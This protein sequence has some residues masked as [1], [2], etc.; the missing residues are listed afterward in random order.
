MQVQGSQCAAGTGFTSESTA[1]AQC[2]LGARGRTTDAEG[3]WTTGCL[4]KKEVRAVRGST[5][6]LLLKLTN[7]AM[8]GQG[9]SSGRGERALAHDGR[10]LTCRPPGAGRPGRRW[11]RR[12]R[13]RRWCSRAGR[14]ARR[15]PSAACCEWRGSQGQRKSVQCQT[16]GGGVSRVASKLPALARPRLPTHQPLQTAGVP[17]GVPPGT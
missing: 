16:W 8:P 5:A 4:L 6:W 12:R 10:R 7:Q 15:R 11:R 3:G 1:Q 9:G 14:R 17:G 13:R 2:G